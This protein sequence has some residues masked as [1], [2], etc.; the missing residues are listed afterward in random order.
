VELAFS[1]EEVLARLQ[2]DPLPDLLLLDYELPR[3]DGREVLDR[4]RSDPRLA[5]LP[6]LMV[7]ASSIDLTQLRRVSGLLRKPYPRAV[8]FKMLREL[9]ERSAPPA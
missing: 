1:G 2:R 9:L 6:V 5:D 8:L 7:T 3:L 4:L